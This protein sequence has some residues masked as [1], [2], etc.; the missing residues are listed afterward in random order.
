[1]VRLAK[2]KGAQFTIST[3]AHDPKHLAGIRYGVT[4][5]RRGWLG[6]ND[7]LNTLP[8]AEF[9]SALKKTKVSGSATSAT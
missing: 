2:A 4:T 1:L 6:K 7:V 5:A 9:A 8:A 3:D